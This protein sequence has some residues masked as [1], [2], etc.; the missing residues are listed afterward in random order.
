MHKNLLKV[1]MISTMLFT[2]V[3]AASVGPV[4]AAEAEAQETEAET[5]LAE[6][7]AGNMLSDVSNVDEDVNVVVDVELAEG[8]ATPLNVILSRDSVNYQFTV[9]KSGDPLKLKPGTY[10]VT[11]VI[12]GNG[13]KLDKGAKLIIDEE[14]EGLYLDFTDPNKD[15][16]FAVSKLVVKNILF[17]PFFLICAAFA[18]FV[19]SHVEA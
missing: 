16:K 1:M 13:H 3:P 10:K 17:I 8:L 18:R 14:T 7:E 4:Y 5:V 15:E 9:N 2:T 6:N 11:K 12:D 19:A